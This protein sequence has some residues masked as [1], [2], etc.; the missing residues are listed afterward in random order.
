MEKIKNY[1]Y[2][3]MFEQINGVDIEKMIGK[4]LNKK[5]TAQRKLQ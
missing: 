4:M 1:L 3:A 2:K 5:L